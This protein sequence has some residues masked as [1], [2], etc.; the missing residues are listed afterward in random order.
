MP[1]FNK[2]NK[3]WKGRIRLKGYPQKTKIGFKTKGEAQKWEI[4][5]K[6]KMGCEKK[7]W[8]YIP[9]TPDDIYQSLYDKYH[10]FLKHPHNTLPDLIDIMFADFNLGYSFVDIKKIVLTKK[11]QK[12]PAKLRL[13]ILKRDNFKC[14]LCGATKN[15]ARLHVD[16]IIAI[17]RG[18]LL[19][20]RNLRT[21]CQRCNLGKS[22]KP[23]TITG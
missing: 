22:N 20:H 14:V 10:S 15:E 17:D 3:S 23:F 18:G 13:E 7:P 19:E 5:I 4:Y 21:L 8:E 1:S 11:Q 9:A 2:K 12:I 6:G 16:H